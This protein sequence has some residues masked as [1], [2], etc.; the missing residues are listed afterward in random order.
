MVTSAIQH[1]T[2]LRPA[3]LAVLRTVLILT[4][5]DHELESV[6]LFVAKLDADIVSCHVEGFADGLTRKHL[7]VEGLGEANRCLVQDGLTL[8]AADH[9]WHIALLED[10]AHELR[11][12]SRD[13]ND[14]DFCRS[15]LQDFAQLTLTNELTITVLCLEQQ[16][17]TLCLT[18]QLHACI[19]L[20]ETV[21]TNMKHA[22]PLADHIDEFVLGRH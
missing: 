9:V 19:C 8:L 11:H 20:I 12:A 22:G 2:F 4:L 21:A 1:S 7:S 3:R 16:V 14:L 18:P 13:E 15:S 10:F 6:G 5:G 17:A